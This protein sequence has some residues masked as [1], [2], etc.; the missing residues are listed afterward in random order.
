MVDEGYDGKKTG[1]GREK[2]AEIRGLFS[3]ETLSLQR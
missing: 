3:N 2:Q 1:R